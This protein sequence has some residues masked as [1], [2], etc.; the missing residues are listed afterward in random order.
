M[1]QFID[2]VPNVRTHLKG[3]PELTVLHYLKRGAKQFCND[4]QI[5]D[6]N[7]G[8]KALQTTATVNR[9]RRIA[10]PSTA[11]GDT[12]FQ[13]PE[14]SYLNAISRVRIATSDTQEPD[15]LADEYWGYD[16]PTRELI[17]QPGAVLQSLTLYVD[18][19]LEVL[20]T[21]TQLPDFLAELWGE[22]ISDYA[23]FEMTSM[24]EVEWSNPELAKV[25]KAKYDSRVSEAV[26]LKA[27]KGSGQPIE[28]D[29][30]PFA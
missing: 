11:A 4:S 5:W 22:G 27:R 20:S 7:I 1:A 18:A 8:S 25:F 12:D 14:Q 24:P 2:L 16:V 15:D 10:V 26:E 9:S 3:A 30:I 28:L 29:P 23:I 17:L 6:V 19:I 21:A 13:L